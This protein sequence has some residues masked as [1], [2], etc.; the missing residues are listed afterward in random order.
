MNFASTKI[1]L[2]KQIA[3]SLESSLSVKH[4]KQTQC[5]QELTS[6]VYAFQAVTHKINLIENNIGNRLE[7]IGDTLEVNTSLTELR[8]ENSKIT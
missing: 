5:S 4:L 3:S 2:L 8:L 7:E 1:I 6:V